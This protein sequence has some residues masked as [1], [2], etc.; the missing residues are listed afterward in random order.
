MAD[1]SSDAAVDTT[2]DEISNE[3]A[4]QNKDTAQDDLQTATTKI[5]GA[6]ETLNE[7]KHV[8]EASAKIKRA[9]N[10]ANQDE[11]S[12]QGAEKDGTAEVKETDPAPTEAVEPLSDQ[13][14]AL[15]EDPKPDTSVADNEPLS[16]GADDQ[17]QQLHPDQEAEASKSPSYESQSNNDTKD[18]AKVNELASD[19]ID[20][21]DSAE[22]DK[23]VVDDAAAKIKRASDTAAELDHLSKAADKVKRSSDTANELD[24]LNKAT[25]K[26]KRSSDT[27]NELENM[28]EAVSKIRDTAH[29]LENLNEATAKVKRSSD[30]AHELENLNE[31]VNKVRDSAHEFE[32]LSEATAK[33]K[34]ASNAVDD[35]E[36]VADEFAEY[37]PQTQANAIDGTDDYEEE[38]T[39]QAHED[40]EIGNQD[41]KNDQNQA[42][43]LREAESQSEQAIAETDQETTTIPTEQPTEPTDLEATDDLEEYDIEQKLNDDVADDIEPKPGKEFV[44]AVMNL[45]E[46]HSEALQVPTA[47]DELQSDTEEATLL[48]SDIDTTVDQDDSAEQLQDPLPN[49]EAEDQEPFDLERVVSGTHAIAATDEPATQGDEL[50]DFDAQME[51]YQNQEP[52]PPSDP[53]P[54]ITALPRDVDLDLEQND[55]GAELS[56][57][58]QV[59]LD[60]DMQRVSARAKG[61]D[62]VEPASTG[63]VDP[64]T[65]TSE[66]GVQTI[67]LATEIKLGSSTKKKLAHELGYFLPQKSASRADGKRSS[68]QKQMSPI[69]AAKQMRS[70]SQKIAR[71]INEHK[72]QLRVIFDRYSNGLTHKIKLDGLTKMLRDRAI[73]KKL[74]LVPEITKAFHKSSFTQ[75]TPSSLSF[76]EF[77]QCI[78]RLAND[79]LSRKK[80]SKYKSAESRVSLFLAKLHLRPFPT[81]DGDNDNVP[82]VEA[83]KTIAAEL[84]PNVGGSGKDGQDPAYQYD[85]RLSEKQLDS[86][87]DHYFQTGSFFSGQQTDTT[88]SK[89]QSVHSVATEQSATHQPEIPTQPAQNPTSP[90]FRK[91]RGLHGD[92]RQQGNAQGS[93]QLAKSGVRRN[94][95]P[96]QYSNSAKRA[97]G[98]QR[99]KPSPFASRPSKAVKK[100][101][102][103]SYQEMHGGPQQHQSPQR[104]SYQDNEA[105]MQSPERVASNS[106]N[107]YQMQMQSPQQV[108]AMQRDNGYG[109]QGYPQQTHQQAMQQQYA[110]RSPERN[111][112]PQAQLASPERQQQQYMESG[113]SSYD[114]AAQQQGYGDYYE[115]QQQHAPQRGYNEDIDRAERELQSQI[116]HLTEQ[117]QQVMRNIQQ[118]Q[119]SQLS[120]AMP[121]P[122]QRHRSNSY[123]NR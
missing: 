1:E 62:E 9:S 25:A 98:S 84:A 118:R 42:E 82:K 12:E 104:K 4:Q 79:L 95:R 103:T 89:S 26:V 66:I 20:P 54:V 97:A 106:P 92:R 50:F 121:P 57:A 32:N 63:V 65:G 10:A 67:I 53:E 39:G 36:P 64:A 120:R 15:A 18:E 38:Q 17:A 88:A 107:P 30:A 35:A 105:N 119:Q 58:E 101:R 33:V 29:E 60:P 2:K 22:Q 99:V 51:T 24:N 100:K 83:G 14:L 94:P 61:L 37:S 23:A 40:S 48:T 117:E 110:M 47:N 108:Q 55:H 78:I 96:P 28:N 31:A 6:S 73:L 11:D 52:E 102:F 59:E 87:F 43:H 8:D 113:G 56:P 77:L 16:G 90:P 109:Q 41:L 114:I 122:Q 72:A 34:R 123:N 76:D 93:P 49:E 3:D 5:R 27:A 86:E 71:I 70:S 21:A 46:T 13:N 75:V 80:K 44:E 68:S 116:N 19:E 91:L 115:P 74:S 81:D 85:Y 112:Y 7:L 69:L 45:T 111:M